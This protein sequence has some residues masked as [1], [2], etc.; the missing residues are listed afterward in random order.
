MTSLTVET[1]EAIVANLVSDL[2]PEGWQVIMHATPGEA[3]EPDTIAIAV[4]ET[5]PLPGYVPPP[6]HILRH[7]LAVTVYG[8][9]S[10]DNERLA[11]AIQDRLLS[12]GQPDWQAAAQAVADE[13]T[14]GVALEICWDEKEESRTESA[15][16]GS[17]LAVTIRHAVVTGSLNNEEAAN[18]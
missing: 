10:Q 4:E 2:V 8:D 11:H 12:L 6:E 7:T 3:L 13:Q 15:Y 17:A 9:R 14:G 1:V 5:T 18:D 16:D